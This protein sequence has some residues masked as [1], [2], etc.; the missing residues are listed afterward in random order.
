VSGLVRAAA[1]PPGG[2]SFERFALSR[3]QSILWGNV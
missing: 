1:K 2:W 3:D